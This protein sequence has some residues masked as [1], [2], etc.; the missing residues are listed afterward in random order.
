MNLTKI[1]IE[2][3]ADNLIKKAGDISKEDFHYIEDTEQKM[4]V[5]F[6]INEMITDKFALLK[7]LR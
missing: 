5:A 4:L 3:I 2:K 1:T 6:P 7:Y